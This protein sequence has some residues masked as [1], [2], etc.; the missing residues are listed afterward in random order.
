M[1]KRFLLALLLCLLPLAALA[2]EPSPDDRTAQLLPVRSLTIK[3]GKSVHRFRVM[4]ARTNAQ[5]EVGLMW[6][7][8]MA[9]DE[10]MIFP[11]P[12]EKRAVFWMKNTFIPLDLL[13]IRKDGRIAN[14][15]VN[16]EPLSL[17]PIPSDGNVRAV[18]EITGGQSVLLGINPG[19][20]VVW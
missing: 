8:A 13:F 17:S 14:I 4:V 15:A 6:R 11:F 7:T 9:A 18:L 5:Q 19:D 1:L 3:S 12:A 16:A 20:R 10:G 2:R